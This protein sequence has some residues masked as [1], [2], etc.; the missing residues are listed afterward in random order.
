M[1]T[2]RRS[3]LAGSA[4]V[5][6]GAAVGAPEAQANPRPDGKQKPTVVL[7]HG[8]F[9]DASGWYGVAAQLIRA[10]YPVLAPANPLRGV[11]ADAAYL[12]SVLATLNGPLVLA[13]HSYGGNVI[14]NA[15]TGNANVKALVYVAAFAPDAGE[16]LQGLQTK[17]P[18]SKVDETA[19]DF[20][21]NG[22]SVDAYIKKEVFRDVFAGDVPRATT[23]LMWA[24]QRPVD[25]RALGEPSGVP[26]W[27]TIPSWYLVARDDN[28]FPAAAQRFVARRAGARTVEVGASHV[29]MISQPAATA[30][31]IKRAAC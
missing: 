23:D 9:A 19:L 25:V 22:A 2:S 26:A 3:L 13:A 28:V 31:L 16:S 24:G 20:R 6:A 27:K 12:A 5:A 1:T 30:D 21:P 15:A 7:V 11:A 17:Y 10:G 29:A 8:A 4:A 18:G 14:T